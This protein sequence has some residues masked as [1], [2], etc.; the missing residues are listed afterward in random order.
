MVAEV[1]VVAEAVV[2]VVA[3]VTKSYGVG[4][5]FRE[6]L[7]T[8][9]FR[10]QNKLGF[11]EIIAEHYLDS[12]KYREKELDL[13]LE[14]FVVIPHAINLSLGTYEGIDESY[15]EKLAK[16]IK[17]INPP[18]WSEHIAFTN[19]NG[20]DI[21]HLAPLPFNNDAIAV[22]CKNVAKVKNHI[23]HNLL[24]ENITYTYK[25]PFSDLKEEDFLAEIL[26]KTDCG[27]LLDITNLYI[28]SINHKYDSNVF[29][30]NIPLD[31]VVQLH[32]IGGHWHNDILIDSHSKPTHKEV[33]DLMEKVVSLGNIK[34]A[35]LEWDE[36]FPDFNDILFEIEKAS[37]IFNGFTANTTHFS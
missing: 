14:T 1:V 24:L 28:N 36:E 37:K 2:D 16:L 17:K 30:K 27:M 15:L 5:G 31:R 29:L 35:V 7:K 8:D 11:I 34:G 23:E 25:Q 20:I 19:S 3:E 33:W 32:F 21:G 12:N 6:E 10:N 26:E 18:W 4:I 13:L 22:V 9:I